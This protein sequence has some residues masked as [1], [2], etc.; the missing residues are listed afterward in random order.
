LS[1]VK[2]YRCDLGSS[3]LQAWSRFFFA[4]A[5]PTA[6]GL[7]RVVVG[8]LLLWDLGV[9]GLDLRDYLGEDGWIGPE[10]AR[11]YLSEHSP[12]AWSFWLWVPDSWLPVAWAVSLA[13]LA[14]FTVGLW[15]RVTAVL[16][17]AIAVS[18]VRRAPVAL[19]GFDQM[20]ATWAFYLAAFGASGQAV[21]LDHFLKRYRLLRQ[22]GV[23][24]G[25]RG[26]AEPAR[27]GGVPA[28]TASANLSLRLIQ[29]HLVF[30]YG[31]AGLA[32]LLAPEW[33]D[34]TAMEMIILTPEFR[35]FDLVWLAAYPALLS[36]AT[37]G[38]VLL[39]IAY[40]VLIWVRKLRPIL[41]ASAAMMHVGIDLMLGLTE[42][43]LAMAAANV[44]FVSGPWLRSLVTGHR[45]PAGRLF[46]DRAC[47]RVRA[48]VT[49]LAA[50]DPDCVIEVTAMDHPAPQTRPPVPTPGPRLQPFACTLVQPDGRSTPG[51]DALVIVMGWLPLL[52]PL[53]LAGKLPF[54]RRVIRAAAARYLGGGQSLGS[55]RKP[56]GSAGATT[57]A[58]RVTDEPLHSAP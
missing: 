11:G 4:P 47:P 8:A 30:V 29:L 22:A 6:L 2:R 23:R 36:L 40:P 5:D 35:R 16:A 50:A 57:V 38:G 24:P 31:S 15:S 27:A 19:F 26:P 48:L 46:Y 43:G 42:F 33:W 41:L 9:L 10:A 28:P 20:I 53:G 7:I 3:S 21:S 39:E 13:V 52:W 1:E 44:A 25:R 12:W 18:T 34:G 56:W 58:S 51:P 55:L 54:L 37:H 32:K 17:W 45:Q 49:L 14:L